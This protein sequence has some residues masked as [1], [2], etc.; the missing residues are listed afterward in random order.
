MSCIHTWVE[1]CS[2]HSHSNRKGVVFRESLPTNVLAYVVCVAYVVSVCTREFMEADSSWHKEN[3]N[4]SSRHIYLLSCQSWTELF[5]KGLGYSWIE[6][7]SS[8]SN[9]KVWVIRK[10]LLTYKNICCIFHPPWSAN[11]IKPK[12]Q[13]EKSSSQFQFSPAN[14]G[15]N[16]CIKD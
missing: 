11:T 16:F 13:T 14:H 12:C 7:S 6:F 4:V 8:H 3:E 10:N 2:S 15:R 1:F 9:R 5:H